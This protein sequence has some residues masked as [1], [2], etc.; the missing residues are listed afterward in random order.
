[1]DST[2]TRST[3]SFVEN[4]GNLVRRRNSTWA[5]TAASWSTPSPGGGEAA[6]KYPV[7]F[8]AVDLVIVTKTDLLPHL[9]ADLGTLDA[10]LVRVNPGVDV[11]R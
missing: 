11:V 2:S 1:M 6:L 7:M 10:N 9:D 5:R 3:L 4:V 8:R